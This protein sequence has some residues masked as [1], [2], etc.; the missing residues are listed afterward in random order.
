MHHFKT[1]QI[2]KINKSKKNIS[3]PLKLKKFSKYCLHRTSYSKTMLHCFI[4]DIVIK[5]SSEGLSI[6]YV[7]ASILNPIGDLA[8]TEWLSCISIIWTEKHCEYIS[9]TKQC[10]FCDSLSLF[11]EQSIVF[12]IVKVINNSCHDWGVDSNQS[13]WLSWIGSWFC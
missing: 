11:L 2:D 8:V 10:L 12:K 9:W 4:F 13:F 5:T 7:L 3:I 1:L 6:L